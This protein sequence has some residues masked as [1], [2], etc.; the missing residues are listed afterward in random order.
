[1]QWPSRTPN[2]WCMKLRQPGIGFT[3]TSERL[4]HVR[5][6]DGRGGEERPS[7][8]LRRALVLVVGDPDAHPAGGGGAERVRHAVADRAGSGTS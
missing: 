3:G 7:T 1:M 5:L 8:V 4:Q 6:R 2:W